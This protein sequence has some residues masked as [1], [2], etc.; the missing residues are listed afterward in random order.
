MGRRLPVQFTMQRPARP[1]AHSTAALRK[2]AEFQVDEAVTRDK[3]SWQREAFALNAGIGQVSKINAITANTVAACDMKIVY[4]DPETGTERTLEDILETESDSPEYDADLRT[5][6]EAAQRV[7]QAFIG[8]KGGK[9]HLLWRAAWHMRVA[10]ESFLVGVPSKDPRVT[11]AGD[12]PELLWEFLSPLEFRQQDDKKWVRDSTGLSS[13]LNPLG[14]NANGDR[15][16]MQLGPRGAVPEEAYSARLWQEDPAFAELPYCS[17]KAAI[18]DMIQYVELRGVIDAAIQTRMS[19]GLLLIDDSLS[20]GPMNEPDDGDDDEDL[21]PFTL[22]LVTHMAA[23]INDRTA[24]S[25]LVPLVVTGKGEFLDKVKMVDLSNDNRALEE[26]RTTRAETLKSILQI[27]DSPPEVVEGKG[28]LNHWTG[29][30][31]DE[32][33]TGRYVI[34]LGETISGFST[35]AFLQ[36][37]LVEYEY[38]TAEE[39]AQWEYRFDPSNITAKADRGV[40]FLRLH[41]RHLVSDAATRGA[42]GAT[43]ADAPSDEERRERYVLALVEKSPSYIPMLQLTD[44]FADVDSALLAEIAAAV[45]G[46]S[47]A[48]GSGQDGAPDGTG[49]PPGA[50]P[51]D[52]GDTEGD[53]RS[54]DGRPDTQPGVEAPDLEVDR[55]M[56]ARLIGL[57]LGEADASIDR[58]LERAGAKVLSRFASAADAD[59]VRSRFV[60]RHKG[61]ALALCT[62]DDL[63]GVGLSAVEL[64][65]GEWDDFKSKA[66]GLIRPW[67]ERSTG[68]NGHVAADTARSCADQMAAAIEQLAV[69]DRGT[70]RYADHLRVPAEILVGPLE[71]VG[72]VRL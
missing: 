30:A 8:P 65:A 18:P 23:P 1:S 21:D 14:T 15:Y 22:R 33:F 3:R 68:Y 34:P 25:S 67:V 32:E 38:F 47:P 51:G 48:G 39:A 5:A 36:Y 45:P 11:P 43:E 72:P 17:M 7:D 9:R 54:G 10:G 61:E 64:L 71:V 12:S 35:Q 60:G 52:R 28:S 40:T 50:P 58:A 57:L 41:D 49:A 55:G 6:A 44:L 66:E 24:G 29:F 19:A 2:V 20:F 59:A 27:L 13:H 42:N 26:L 70:Q 53:P 69:T 56:D 37:M 63:A 16:A 62:D 4:L 46:L 31:V